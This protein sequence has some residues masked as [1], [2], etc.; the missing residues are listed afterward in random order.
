MKAIILARVSSKEQE[1]GMS[2]PAQIRRIEEY[3][4]RKGLEISHRFQITE[5]STRGTRKEFEKIIQLIRKTKHTI[6]LVADNIDRVQRSF[7]ESVILDDLRREGKVVIHFYRESLI[8]D[9]DSNSSDLM[10]WD[11]G[12]MF[13]RGYVLQLS[14]NVKRAKDEALKN[15]IWVGLAPFGYLHI[16]DNNGEKTISPNQTLKYLISQMFELYATG[17]YSLQ[18]LTIK[19]KDLGLRSK[20]D[21]PIAR[22]QIESMLKNPF[23]HGV[24]RTKKG[25]FTHKYETIISKHTFDRVQDVFAS[26]NKKPHKPVAAPFVFKGLITCNNCG[27]VIT[28]ETKKGKYVYYSCSNAKG[29]CKRQY[30]RE[31][32]LLET[33]SGYFKKIQLPEETIQEITK[34]L[35]SIHENESHFHKEHIQDLQKEQAKIQQRISLMYDDKLDGIIDET[36]FQ[37]KLKEYKERQ[38]EIVEDIGR[39]EKGDEAFHVTANQAMN[40]AKRAWDL[41]ESSEV[42]EKRQLLNFVL[43]NL[44][45]ENK[46][47]LVE[48]REPFNLLIEVG[49]CPKGWGR[50]GRFRTFDWGSIAESVKLISSLLVA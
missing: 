13:A 38:Y 44:K 30:V 5:S 6:A 42:D 18:T 31:E 37:E 28:P 22:S 33:V 27:C 2:I 40:L 25:F 17:N 3:S 45:L 32:V 50:L 46:K 36:M 9:K 49:S 35:R 24:M 19:M 15:G 34:Y 20:K 41:F 26:Y 4:E 1:E 47:L 48:V 11:M 16:L 23:Y 21:K 29:N 14:D 12:V 8:L 43:Q 10:R 39:H 7:K